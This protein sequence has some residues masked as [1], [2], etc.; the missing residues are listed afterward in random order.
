VSITLEAIATKV[1][2]R[3][4]GVTET[5]GQLLDLL[6]AGKQSK[7]LVRELGVSAAAIKARKRDLRL[8][9]GAKNAFQAAVIAAKRGL[10]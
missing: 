10:L 4:H 1:A 3:K 9:L 5:Q 2:R 8:K 7:Q 6:S